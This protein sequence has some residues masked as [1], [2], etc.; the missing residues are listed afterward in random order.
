MIGDETMRRYKLD[1][2]LREQYLAVP[3]I[4]FVPPYK[5]LSNDTRF[6]YAILRERIKLSQKNKW[7]NEKNEVYVI[8]PLK[9][10]A[11]KW[12]FSRSTASRLIEQLKVAGLI[13]TERLGQGKA[14]RIF[15]CLPV[16]PESELDSQ[17]P[18]F[19]NL[20]PSDK[21]PV[22]SNSGILFPEMGSINKNIDNI[23]IEKDKEINTYENELYVCPATTI[24]PDRHSVNNYCK[25]RHNQIDP[26]EFIDYYTSRGW[27]G[28]VDWQAQIRQWERR[29][30][31]RSASQ[32]TTYKQSG[33][34]QRLDVVN[35]V[36][37]R[38]TKGAETNDSLDE[39]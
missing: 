2:T 17:N 3:K 38:L 20:I 33:E 24:P 4:L 26:D 28:I 18:N 13:E 39:S 7:I 30:A 32:L 19:R 11:T 27:K 37:K 12:G 29:Q 9:E 36:I 5:K 34:N 25:E 21:N 35:N 6:L 23:I 31:R 22:A 14:N 16:L 1:D 10:I 15:V 8:Y